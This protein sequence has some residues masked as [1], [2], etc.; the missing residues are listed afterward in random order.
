MG[1][2]YVHK[3]EYKEALKKFE[4]CLEIK[5]RSLGNDHPTIAT[6]LSNIGSI[7]LRMGKY[8]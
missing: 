2:I 3:G 8:E 1:Y 4:A 6:T 5:T 7:Y